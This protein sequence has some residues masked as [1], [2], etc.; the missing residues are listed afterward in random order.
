M[1]AASCMTLNESGI[2]QLHAWCLALDRSRLRTPFDLQCTSCGKFERVHDICP[3]AMP[4]FHSGV[5]VF[6]TNVVHHAAKGQGS[7]TQACRLATELNA[8]VPAGVTIDRCLAK[9]AART[10]GI[11]LSVV[12]QPALRHFHHH[13]HSSRRP[14]WSFRS[15]TRSGKVGTECR[16]HPHCCISP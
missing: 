7:I 8:T 4:C 9:P 2:G 11:R 5:T 1:T 12:L 15:P 3:A 14:D 10:V 16:S 6:E 13:G